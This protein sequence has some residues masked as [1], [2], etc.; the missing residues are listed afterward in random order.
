MVLAMVSLPK[1]H[2]SLLL[3]S[4]M[5]SSLCC[6]RGW[7]TLQLLASFSFTAD[8]CPP[9]SWPCRWGTRSWNTSTFTLHPPAARLSRLCSAE[10]GSFWW[11][12]ANLEMIYDWGS[13][14][15]LACDLIP[16]GAVVYCKPL[17]FFCYSF[18]SSAFYCW[19][20]SSDYK[21]LKNGAPLV[22]E[23]WILEQTFTYFLVSCFQHV[24][25]PRVKSIVLPKMKI[26]WPKVYL[27]FVSSSEQIWRNFA[28][29]YLITNGSSAVNGCHQN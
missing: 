5:S 25:L 6:K 28:L 24:F 22:P 2:V 13:A 9:L 29:H 12:F 4:S 10:K 27:D 1:N 14:P 7:I 8:P 20:S 11:V 3:L 19:I 18:S 23:L 15:F 26:C 16:N 21:C 17:F